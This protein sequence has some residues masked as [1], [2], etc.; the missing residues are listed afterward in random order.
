MWF[1]K[2][3]NG[4]DKIDLIGQE[5]WREKYTEGDLISRGLF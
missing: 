4:A 5:K 1:L 3:F 2:R